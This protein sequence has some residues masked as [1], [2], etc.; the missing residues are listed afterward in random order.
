LKW[1]IFKQKKGGAT[2]SLGL[3]YCSMGSSQPQ[4][5]DTVPLKGRSE[6]LFKV[7]AVFG[8]GL[9]HALLA[10]AT[11]TIVATVSL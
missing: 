3:N 1:P 2:I 10:S 5:R 7:L 4:S 8:F 9:I 11:T 6:N